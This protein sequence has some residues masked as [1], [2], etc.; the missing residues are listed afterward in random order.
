ME[1]DPGTR[2]RLVPTSVTGEPGLTMVGE[3]LVMDGLRTTKFCVL[4]TVVPLTVTAMGP[5]TAAAGTVATSVKSVA[6]VT[7]AAAP[8]IV[9]PFWPGSGSNPVPEIVT[10]LPT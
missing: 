7:T 1:V 8:P 3:K 2:F 9:T 4:V 6:A 10:W 5:D